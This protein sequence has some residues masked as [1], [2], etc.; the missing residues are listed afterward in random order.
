MAKG[1]FKQPKKRPKFLTDTIVVKFVDQLNIPYGSNTDLL[2]NLLPQFGKSLVDMLN[3]YQEINIGRLVTSITETQMTYLVYEAKER[4]KQMHTFPGPTG[5]YNP[6]NFHNFL[7]I[8]CKNTTPKFKLLKLLNEQGIVEYAYIQGIILPGSSPPLRS[9]ALKS[10]KRKQGYLNAGPEGINAKYA[11][12]NGGRG[13]GDFR[14][15]D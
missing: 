10:Y 14:F 13:K 12:A 6:P 4:S 2:N 15:I 5:L 8:E 9:N 7:K 1:K 3:K 11:R